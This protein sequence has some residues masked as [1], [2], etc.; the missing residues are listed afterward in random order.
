MIDSQVFMFDQLC[1]WEEIDIFLDKL[2]DWPEARKAGLDYIER[3]G[4]DCKV[5]LQNYH[6]KIADNAEKRSPI[7]GGAMT[8]EKSEHAIKRTWKWYL[9]KIVKMCIPYGIL[10]LYQMERYPD[11]I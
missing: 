10:R 8:A 9:K 6:D 3:K 5:I 1:L 11:G 7:I 2:N 4:G